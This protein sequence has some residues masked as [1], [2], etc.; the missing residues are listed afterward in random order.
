M[1]ASKSWLLGLGL[2]LGVATSLVLPASPAQAFEEC[3]EDQA[4]CLE[5]LKGARFQADKQSTAKERKKRSKKYAGTLSLTV[6]GGRGSLFIN[7]RYAGTAPLDGIEIPAGKNDIQVRDGATVI[8][9][10]VLT[11]PREGKVV[12]T[13]RVR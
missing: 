12:A 7:G 2:S 8:A 11:V 5:P 3:P 1:G 10:G 6:E 4:V 9:S 13:V